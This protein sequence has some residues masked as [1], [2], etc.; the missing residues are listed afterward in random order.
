MIY[1]VT[2]H[3]STLPIYQI[4]STQK[5]PTQNLLHDFIL[6]TQETSYMKWKANTA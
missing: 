5:L 2:F 3:I 6:Y 1:K 4:L